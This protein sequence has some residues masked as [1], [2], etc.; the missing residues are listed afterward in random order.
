MNRGGGIDGKGA[1]ALRR[2]HWQRVLKAVRLAEAC[3]VRIMTMGCEVGNL[4]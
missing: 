2:K 3:A 4:V 1:C